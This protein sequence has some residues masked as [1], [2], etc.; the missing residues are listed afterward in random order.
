MNKIKNFIANKK[1]HGFIIPIIAILLGFL[2]GSLIMLF[3]G[4]NPK[5]LFI[6]LVRAITG[7][8]VNNIGTNKEIFN[9]RYIGEYFVY[10][11]PLILT[12][13]SV[14]FA[15]RTGLFNIGAEGQV[16]LGA[17]MATYVALTVNLPKSILLPAVII[18]GALAGALW[19]FIP[20]I[21]KAKFNVSEVVVTIMLN[22][23]G[24]YTTNY[25]I[26]SLP[27]ST[28][29]RT[30]DLPAASLLKSDL[31]A[32]LTNNSRLHYGFIVVILAVLAFWFIIEKTTFGYE[33]KSVGY[34]PFASRYAGMKVERNAALSMAIA[35]A[36]SGLAGAILVSGTFGYGRVLGSFEN[37]G[38]DG[39]AVALIGGSTAFGSVL[40]G[41]L[42]GA[43]KAAQPIMQINRIPRDIAIIIIAS[44][45]IFIAMRN[46]IKM[47]L[48]KV[49]VK[50]VEK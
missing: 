9:A 32:G 7:I 38:F 6:S 4:L 40:G 10:V 16:M 28:S 36:F 18:S 39:I 15:F 42:F 3:T 46:G 29:T 24:L 23:V 27:G 47:A 22:Y 2:V 5:D 50:E 49:K 37:Y 45:V 1:N 25:F 35:G 20:G 31:L 21:L 11:M 30:V 26:R 48:E 19:G 13:L 41:L 17:F 12:G 14:A 8:N 44:I 33:L 43:L 34:N